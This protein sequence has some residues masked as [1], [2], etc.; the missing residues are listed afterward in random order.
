MKQ[1]L[2]EHLKVKKKFKS[3]KERKAYITSTLKLTLQKDPSKNNALCVPVAGDTLMLAGVRM[4]AERV[5]KES[6]DTKEDAKESFKRAAEEVQ[7]TTNSK[8]W[9]CGTEFSR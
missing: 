5:K 3:D 2:D 1:Y 7:A 4:A 9:G 6:H 8:A